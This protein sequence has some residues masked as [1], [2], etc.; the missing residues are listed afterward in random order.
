MNTASED[1][2]LESIQ[3]ALKAGDRV[4]T[5]IVE[6]FGYY[7]GI[8]IANMMTL[9]FS[10]CIVLGGPMFYKLNTFYETVVKTATDRLNVLYPGY[11]VQFRKGK[12][13]EHATAIGAG[14]MVFDYYLN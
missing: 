4:S 2:H 8:G 6:E 5:E 3:D 13:G 9:L 1:I 7:T 14:S 11:E 10:E 12:L